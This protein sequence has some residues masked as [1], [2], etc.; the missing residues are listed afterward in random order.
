[1]SLKTLLLRQPVKRR[2]F[3]DKAA[4]I[5]ICS[6]CGLI[7]DETGGAIDQERWVTK[8][9]YVKTHGMNLAD[10][11][12]THTYCPG[13]F[14]DFIERVRPRTSSIDMAH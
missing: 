14:T 11:N 1:M 4:L 8:R 3:A 13:C 6:S 5:P 12:L 10:C 9:M 2:T 7:R